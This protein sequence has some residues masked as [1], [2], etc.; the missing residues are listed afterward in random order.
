MKK[1]LNNDFIC[2]AIYPTWVANPIIQEKRDW[3]V[4]VDFTKINKVYPKNNFL[5][6]RIDQMVDVIVGHELLKILGA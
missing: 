2:E 6:P 4:Y 5:L 1:L 3:R